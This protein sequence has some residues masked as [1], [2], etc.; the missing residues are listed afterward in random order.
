MMHTINTQNRMERLQQFMWSSWKFPLFANAVCVVSFVV[1]MGEHLIGS[2]RG[3]EPCEWLVLPFAIA[4]L[5]LCV[6]LQFWPIVM[7]VLCWR[8]RQ[9]WHI[10]RCWSAAIGISAACGAAL[11]PIVTASYYTDLYML[12]VELPGGK[13]Y[14]S[15]RGMRAYVGDA[16][17]AAAAARELLELRPRRQPLDVLVQMPPLPNLEKLTKEAPGV[18]QEYLL[19]CL[20]AEA[21]NP[22]FDAQVLCQGHE[23]VLLSHAN[24]PQSMVLGKDYVVSRRHLASK[25]HPEEDEMTPRPWAHPLHGGWSVV[26]NDDYYYSDYLPAEEQ[27]AGPLRLLDESLAPLAANP[28]LAGLDALLPPLPQKPFLCLLCG[29]FPGEYRALVILPPGHPEGI[30]ELRAREVSTGK[31]VR[32]SAR[33]K[34][35]RSM[36]NVCSAEWHNLK[37]HSGNVNEFYATEWEIWFTPT[38][39]GEARC[40]GKQEFLMMG[41]Y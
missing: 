32:I 30:V 9:W 36:G 16:P 2:W 10:L 13:E 1:G 21:T 14:V 7:T 29:V 23:P 12:D 3:S 27:V 20:Y 26:L 6:G 4:A 34:S 38:D 19:R 33:K 18:L 11:I 5:F 22:R 37:V 35:L 39:G 28:T 41:G 40:I 17:A 31:P 8:R 15:P 24:D 25:L